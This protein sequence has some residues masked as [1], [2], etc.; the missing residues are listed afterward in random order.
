MK[1][2]L[3]AAAVAVMVFAF[4]AM[5]ASLTVETSTLAT[6]T[7]DVNGCGTLTVDGW[8]AEMSD[9]TTR[10]V[11]FTEDLVA[12]CG[13]GA[14]IA[15]VKVF[16]DVGSEVGSSAQIDLS[17]F[18]QGDNIPLAGT[19]AATYPATE[20]IHEIKVLIHTKNLP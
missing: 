20:D 7:G 10:Y 2:Y 6:G 15:F 19:G 13:S 1:K 17:S 16:D 5:A 14:D 3:A 12:A 18:T 9:D 11:R 8:G 4:A